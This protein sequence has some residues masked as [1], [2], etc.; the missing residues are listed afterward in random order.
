MATLIFCSMLAENDVTV[1]PS[2][3]CMGWLHWWHN[4][5]AHLVSSSTALAFVTNMSEKHKSTSSSAFP[6]KN[7]WET[8][9]TEEKLDIISQLEKGGQIV[10]MS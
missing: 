10:D 4:H 6:V 9:G 7:Q 8:I 2:V 5:T 1:T 3:M